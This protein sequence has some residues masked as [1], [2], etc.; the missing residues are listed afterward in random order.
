MSAREDEASLKE[1]IVRLT[2]L[3]RAN[4]RMS[5][6]LETLRTEQ[7][8]TDR[9]MQMHSQATKPVNSDLLGTS[10]MSRKRKSRRRLLKKGLGVAAG[11]GAG[12]LLNAGEDTAHASSAHVN[13]TLGPTTFNNNGGTSPAVTANSTSPASSKVNAITATSNGYTGVSGKTKASSFSASGVYGQGLSVGVAG[14]VQGANT[15][16]TIKVGVYGTGSNGSGLGGIGVQGQSDNQSGVV[17][18]SISG[19]GVYG[20]ST[21][22]SSGY[23]VYGQ[24]NNGYGV[25]GSG[26]R[27]VFGQ[28]VSSYGV[29]GI[30]DNN[31]GVWGECYVSGT[32]VVGSG[33]GASTLSPGNVG[34][35]GTGSNGS[36]NG[37]IGVY[38]ESDTNN[39]VVGVSTNSSD[40]STAGVVGTGRNG[41]VGQAIGSTTSSNGRVGVYG[42]A[43]N[44][45]DLGGIG[46]YG[47]GD[48]GFGMYAY[49]PGQDGWGIGAVGDSNIG[50]GV[51]TDAA[52]GILSFGNPTAGQFDGDVNVTGTLT[53][54]GGYFKIDHPLDPA[55][56][57]LYHSFVESPDMK[58][59]YDGVVT[60]DA[61]GEASVTLPSWFEALNADFRYQLTPVGAASPNLH[62]AAEISN[63]SF[64]IAGGTAGMKVS[65]QVTGIRQDQ[66]AKANP[67]KVEQ[68]KATKDRGHY[69]YPELF[70][71]PAEKG[72]TTARYASKL[73]KHKTH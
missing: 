46:V 43:S 44:G 5:E 59:V 24:N 34:V 41:V 18:Q 40:D 35:Y 3:E 11:V 61:S 28:S 2:E 7:V 15:A 72:I 47:E 56:K 65:W 49:C 4:V 10:G 8:T 37:G 55:N 67:T 70:G 39:G 45:S 60:L 63:L 16:P 26:A 32:G 1:L 14:Q 12:V 66:W 53:K 31:V 25:V 71:Q 48:T 68:D 20:T 23:G 42:T 17:G 19:H 64:K 57:Y 69:L 13:G 27:G 22:S 62:I 6:E 36:S 33:P 73:S 50:I 54:G 58:N 21:S 29:L 30:S 52:T 9:Q 38:G 51:Y